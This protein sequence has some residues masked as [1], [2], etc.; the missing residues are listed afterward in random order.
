MTRRKC[1]D[2]DYRQYIFEQGAMFGNSPSCKGELAAM[3][4]RMARAARGPG[5]RTDE[6]GWPVG[7]PPEGD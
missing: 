4:R 5:V 1:S 6:R 3:Y 2:K 7:M